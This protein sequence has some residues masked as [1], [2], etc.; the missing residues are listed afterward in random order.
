MWIGE[1]FELGEE[2]LWIQKYLDTFG[3]GLKKSILVL[4]SLADLMTNWHYF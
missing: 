4:V 1:I 2:K 3:W